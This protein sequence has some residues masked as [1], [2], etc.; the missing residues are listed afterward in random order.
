MAALALLTPDGA[1]VSRPI[2]L[3]TEDIHLWLS[4]RINQ[5]VCVSNNI[6]G[7]MGHISLKYRPPESEDV[8]VYSSHIYTDISQRKSIALGYVVGMKVIVC[9]KLLVEPNIG[10]YYAPDVGDRNYLLKRATIVPDRRDN[11]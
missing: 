9:G 11:H 5:K 6:N 8:G 2:S 1:S 3:E 10:S 4:A 7:T